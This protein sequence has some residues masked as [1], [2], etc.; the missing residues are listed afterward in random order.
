MRKTI[1]FLLILFFAGTVLTSCED[2]FGEFLDKQ[3]SNELTEEEVFS[4]W[5]NTQR[6]HFD[7]YNF[8]RH[9]AGRINGSWMDAATD[10]GHTSF[11]TG[12]TRSSFNIGNYYSAA[13]APE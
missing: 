3:P 9:G 10:L 6:F 12:G 13:G 7:T 5:S 8:L 1:Y 11:S 2:M 4:L